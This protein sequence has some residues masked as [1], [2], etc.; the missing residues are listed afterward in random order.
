LRGKDRKDLG[1]EGGKLPTFQIPMGKVLIKW[2]KI[3]VAVYVH[4]KKDIRY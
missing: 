2:K 3:G 4:R 1:R